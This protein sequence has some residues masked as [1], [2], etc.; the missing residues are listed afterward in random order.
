MLNV[1]YGIGSNIDGL[2]IAVKNDE[3]D[4]VYCKTHE[5]NGCI[6]DENNNQSTSCIIMDYYRSLNYKMVST[7][8][9]CNIYIGINIFFLTYAE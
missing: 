2:S 7:Q 4:Y 8:N 1:N 9:R 6:S 3:I 5:L